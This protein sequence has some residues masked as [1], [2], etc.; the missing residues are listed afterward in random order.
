LT[1]ARSALVF[2]W[3]RPRLRALLLSSLLALALLLGGWLWLRN[4]SLV[5]VQHVQIS[6]VSGPEAPA[7]DAALT[8]AARHMSTLNIRPAALRAAV[9]QFRVVRDVRA[10][11]G[12]PHGLRIHVFE[13]PPV[14]ALVV[15][16]QRTAVAADGVVLGSTLL[17]S[18]LPILNAGPRALPGARVRGQSLLAALTVLGAAP[19]RLGSAVAKV[20]T[21]S[22]GLTLVM[23]NGLVAY[24]GDA[25]RPHAR[26]LSLASVLAALSPAGASYVDLRLPERPAAGLSG[27]S[28]V[29]ARAGGGEPTSVSDPTTAA[30]LAAGLQGAVG[31]SP[32]GSPAGHEEASTSGATKAETPTTAPTPA[33]PTEAT[34]SASSETTG[35]P[36]ANG[37]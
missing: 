18:S 24:F 14:A 28:S 29:E 36:P 37:P 1:L 19:Q 21:G 32:A 34:P 22:K 15:G 33:T 16:G 30:K 17:S 27:A 25:T 9:A 6:G 5:S 3:R 4:S 12:F 31:N 35:A 13:R 11:P 8:E 26:W 23:H 2:V 10:T 7:I 20:F